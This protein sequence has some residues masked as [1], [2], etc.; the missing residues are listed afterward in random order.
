MS[1]PNV[2]FLLTDDQDVVLGSL[3]VM[4]KLKKLV[5]DQGVYFNNAFVNTPICCPSRC[6][7]QT[8]RLMH[9]TKAYNN[10]CG[11]TAFQQGPETKNVAW[12]AK[13]Q[14]YTTYYSGKYLNNYGS[15]GTGGVK[16]I[17]P[18]WDEWHALLGNSKYYNYQCSNNGKLVSHGHDY[19][20][21]YY[22]DVLK[23]ESVAWLLNKWDRS[24]PFFMMV[25]TPC[26]HVPNNFAPQY[27]EL[28]T[29]L[30]S[31]RTPNWNK[32]P[33][34]LNG[35]AA[36]HWMMRQFGPMG[37]EGIKNSDLIFQDRWRC[38]QS[39]DDM[40]E[41]LFNTFQKLGQM[42]NTYFIYTG[43][44]GQHLGQFAMGFDK[45]QLYETDIRVPL[46]VKGPGVKPNSTQDGIVQHADLAPTIL[47]M[48]GRETPVD[49][50]DGASWLPLI[51]PKL[52]SQKRLK[53]RKDILIEYGGPHTPPEAIRREELLFFGE[54]D[55]NTEN[56][57]WNW[58][59][60]INRP[61]L[62]NCGSEHGGCP[63][64]ASNNIYRCLRTINNTENSIYCEFDEDFND[65]TNETLFD[66]V[67]WYDI[68]TDPWQMNNLAHIKKPD[69]GKM[70]ALHARLRDYMYCNGSTCFDPPPAP[71]IMK[72]QYR[73][74][75]K[76]LI[77]DEPLTMGTCSSPSSY[78]LEKNDTLGTGT[79]IHAV[80]NLC[81]NVDSVT[82]PKNCK[83]GKHKIHTFQCP[84]KPGPTDHPADHF[85]FDI[86][87]SVIVN[88]VCI[89]FDLCITIDN[90]NQA[91]LG[92]CNDTNAQFQRHLI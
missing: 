52:Q 75:G 11:G 35:S 79:I 76:C 63:C 33:A 14:G 69:V 4:P 30:T 37:N 24:T 39:V 44:H 64:D 26:P 72:F 23:N 65:L 59:E 85:H 42:N 92:Y 81:I 8:G 38:L 58:A 61:K 7:I 16:Y 43:D 34:T 74:N 57:E 36:K 48:M 50:M 25:G 80:N 87:R 28:F 19:S 90:S 71:P 5:T 2:F 1:K 51:V 20:K 10:G 68:S 13:Q 66:F 17:P 3:S 6:E 73:Q 46:I 49:I 32:A 18:G 89:D 47:H 55:P 54:A 60:N 40:V 62:G 12:F 77:G 91:V 41:E 31:P 88:E 21:D 53:W 29:N 67:E 84:T 70:A 78:F 9:N 82:Q 27:A 15:D 86:K 56:Q 22:T 83:A 45:R